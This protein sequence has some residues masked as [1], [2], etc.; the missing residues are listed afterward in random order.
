MGVK[1]LTVTEPNHIQRLP[2]RNDL[3]PEINGT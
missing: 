1:K 2:N 3:E